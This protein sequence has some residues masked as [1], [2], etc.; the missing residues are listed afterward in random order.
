MAAAGTWQWSLGL[1]WCFGLKGEYVSHVAAWVLSAPRFENMVIIQ[2]D[3]TERR[4]A[5]IQ[6]FCGVIE[7]LFRLGT[8]SLVIENLGVVPV[9]VPS[10]Q[11][12]DLHKLEGVQHMSG[13]WI[14]DLRSRQRQQLAADNIWANTWKLLLPLQRSEVC[15]L[16]IAPWEKAE[17]LC[18][19]IKEWYPQPESETATLQNNGI[20]RGFAWQRLWGEHTWKN[21]FL[22]QVNHHSAHN[23][24]K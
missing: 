5:Y 23:C 3:V 9:G 6:H 15:N 20:L 24:T 12:P 19:T 11:L 2:C 18:S 1:I 14:A 7:K 17:G 13:G 8:H 16:S 10:P 22:Q 21:G 4:W